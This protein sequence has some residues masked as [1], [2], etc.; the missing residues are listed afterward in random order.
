[1]Q[2]VI[3]AAGQ[4]T[5]LRDMAPVKPLA[6]IA[7]R[8][9]L[10]FAIR[11]LTRIG[12]RDIIVVTGYEAQTVERHVAQGDWGAPVTCRFNP[13]WRQPNGMSVLAAAP[14][15]FG[16]AVLTMADHI[17]DPEI[18]ALVAAAKRCTLAVDRRIGHPWIDENDV[19][20]VV[21][22]D[23]H[24]AAIGKHIEP[25]DCYDTGV[26]NMGPE[27]VAALQSLAAPSLSQGIS[28]LAGR[29]H[30]DVVDIGTLAWIDVDDARAMAIATEWVADRNAQ[31]AI[32]CAA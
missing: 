16:R 25:Y 20:R 9:L 29:G 1:M 4:G 24:I 5:R 31:G 11:G 26:F 21:T 6:E 3:L 12:I 13:A 17:A 28:L 32:Q 7:G 23:N 10:D 2:A 8:P 27:L 14:L 22:N 19:T 18:Y 15:L 30:A